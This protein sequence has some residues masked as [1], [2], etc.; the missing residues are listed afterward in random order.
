[1]RHYGTRRTKNDPAVRGRLRGD[2][3]TQAERQN[4]HGGQERRAFDKTPQVS[5][6]RT[7]P[8]SIYGK[9]SIVFGGRK[10]QAC[11]SRS[12]ALG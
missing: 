11:L 1:M 3:A 9:A 8:D 2:A 7:I 10:R 12:S 5:H 6:L 4:S